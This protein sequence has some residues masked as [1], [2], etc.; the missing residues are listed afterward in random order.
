MKNCQWEDF[1]PLNPRHGSAGIAA[2]FDMQIEDFVGAHNVTR[3]RQFLCNYFIRESCRAPCLK[4]QTDVEAAAPSQQLVPPDENNS[5]APAINVDSIAVDVVLKEVCEKRLEGMSRCMG[6]QADLYKGAANSTLTCR[7]QA[8]SFNSQLNQIVCY[9]TDQGLEQCQYSASSTP[10]YQDMA[11]LGRPSSVDQ[12]YG[13]M[14]MRNSDGQIVGTCSATAFGDGSQAITAA[15]CF[16]QNGGRATLWTPDAQGR[17]QSTGATCVPNEQYDYSHNTLVAHDTVI[18]NLDSRAYVNRTTFVATRDSSIR[19]GCIP[20]DYYLRCAP[21][22]FERI[23]GTQVEV[24]GFPAS[25]KRDGQFRPILS[26]G[27]VYYDPHSSSF[28]SDTVS[29]PG[30][31]GAGYITDI[32]GYRVIL[33]N[34]SVRYNSSQIGGA[35]VI[36]WTDVARMRTRLTAQKVNGAESIFR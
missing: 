30:A 23:N 28:T 18:C 33:T 27:R 6:S 1:E 29:D 16:D 20:Q 19:S 21:Q 4:Y 35:P 24:V 36:E 34:H 5:P 22:E 25:Q 3:R 12:S 13:Q 31:S 17:M 14:Q 8:A 10:N 7:R 2:S 26:N 15:H 32:N 11:A 9:T